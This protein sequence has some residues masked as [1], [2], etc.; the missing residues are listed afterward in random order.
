MCSAK[1]SRPCWHTLPLPPSICT[2]CSVQYAGLRAGLPQ[3]SLALQLSAS[4]SIPGKGIVQ[5]TVEQQLQSPGH[6]QAHLQAR[7]S[8][9]KSAPHESAEQDV[10]SLGLLLQSLW[11][12]SSISCMESPHAM[13]TPTWDRDLAHV[14]AMIFI[15]E[16]HESAVQDRSIH[17]PE[18]VCPVW[19][20]LPQ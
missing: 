5:E 17:P 15:P 16:A 7:M 6:H 2:T 8:T 19:Y 18:T 3:R 1:W 4:V 10:S 13:C 12:D 11:H 14:P 20:Y 9:L